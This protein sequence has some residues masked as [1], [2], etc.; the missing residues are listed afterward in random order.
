[1]QILGILFDKDGTLLDFQQTWMPAYEAAV[2][3]L[4][5]WADDGALRS[6]CLAAGGKDPDGDGVDPASLLAAGANDELAGVW[7]GL[8]GLPDTAEVAGR[9]IRVMEF[10]AAENPVPLVDIAGLF[11][12][13]AGRGLR[14]GVATMDAEWVA[15][16]N[17]AQLAADGFVSYIAGYDSGYPVKPAPEMVHG[18]CH[19]VTLPP[20]RVMV[21][22]DSP[23]DLEM[24][25]AAGAGRVVGV[26]SGVADEAALAPL[27]DSVI[28]NVGDI[29][30]QLQ[31]S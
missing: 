7:A 8:S 17:L 29:E 4:C 13:L 15:R 12:R 1:L 6:R 27:A 20:D 11:G 24:A 5:D 10:R 26:R 25:R 19:A 9:L 30:G 18:F 14:L 28:D 23:L 22:G 31:D 16:R 21:V 3:A 2:E